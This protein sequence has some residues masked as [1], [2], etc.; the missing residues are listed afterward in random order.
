MVLGLPWRDVQ[1]RQAVVAEQGVDGVLRSQTL[2]IHVGRTPHDVEEHAQMP[3]NVVFH[4]TIQ[5]TEAWFSSPQFIHG[6]RIEFERS[7]NGH[8]VNEVL[9]FRRGQVGQDR[10]H[11]VFLLQR[12]EDTEH[13][14]Q[15]SN[16]ASDGCV[17][18]L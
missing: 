16:P 8:F 17:S 4:A 2:V 10:F 14:S 13:R 11:F 18:M 1:G 6:A 5:H 15:L 12:S 7:V 3:E 9:E